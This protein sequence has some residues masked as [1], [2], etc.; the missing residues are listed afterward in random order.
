MFCIVKLRIYSAVLVPTHRRNTNI[1]PNVS[2]PSSSSL[3]API[4]VME[5]T[6][7]PPPPAPAPVVTATPTPIPA[8]TPPT[9]PTRSQHY[10]P[11]ENTITNICT[12]NII[13]DLPQVTTRSRTGAIKP[14]PPPAST[15]LNTA[16][17]AKIIIKQTPLPSGGMSATVTTASSP[18]QPPPLQQ[19]QSTPPPPRLQQMVHAQAP[20]PLQAKPRG[21]GG[22]AAAATTAPPPLKV[23]PSARQS[24]SSASIIV[25]SSGETSTTVS[26]ATSALAVE[27]GHTGEVTGGEEVVEGEE[28]VSR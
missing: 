25:T 8:P 11:E 10:N 19:M 4:E 13:L 20:P 14:Q 18:R 9:R 27:V 23:V 5:T 24:D 17:V 7:S 2:L 22:G 16:P 1:H 6:P 3:Q 15:A 26:A 28:G 21:G 12:S